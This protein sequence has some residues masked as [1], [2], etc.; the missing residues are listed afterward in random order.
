MEIGTDFLFLG[1]KIT[2]DGD[3]SYEIRR[4]LF[5]GRKDIANLA[6]MLKS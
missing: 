6:S 4:Q 3:Y 2:V 5:L 1:S